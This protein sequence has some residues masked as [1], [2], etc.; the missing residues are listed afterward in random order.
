MPR[1]RLVASLLIAFSL[2]GT[3]LAARAVDEGVDYLTLSTPRP[4]DAQGKIELLEF[5][6]YGCPH[7]YRLEPEL[8]LWTK[9]LPKDVVLRRIP[10]TLNADWEPLT[11]AYYALEALGLTDKL[12]AKLFEAIHVDGM[13]LNKPEKFFDWVA[14]Q[15]VD[16]AKIAQAYNSFSVNSK[17]M[18]SRQVVQDYKLTGV[19]AFAV[20]GKYVTSAYM[21]GSNPALF[22]ALDHLIKKEQAGGK[23]K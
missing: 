15:G 19:P 5:F 13:N 17:V 3:P 21:T 16:K 1:T 8:N 23:R 4:T 6:W 20:N 7:C 2:I 18:R 12:H 22:E 14:K 11:R 9:K 10:A